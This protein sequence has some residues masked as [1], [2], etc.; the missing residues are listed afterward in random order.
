MGFFSSIPNVL[1]VV[2]VFGF[3]FVLVGILAAIFGTSL[4]A[5]AKES[6]LRVNR[7]I[8]CATKQ[9]EFDV[10][11]QPY[12]FSKDFRDVKRCSAFGDGPVTC[13]KDCLQS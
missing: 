1:I 9:S 10:Q 3:P 2:I 11:F 5:W 12:Q 4:V 8:I 13:G 7:R 6:T